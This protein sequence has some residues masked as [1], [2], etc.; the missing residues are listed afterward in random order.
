V[1]P[2]DE[3]LGRLLKLIRTRTGLTQA[4]LAAN[5]RVP[6]QDLKRLESGAAGNVRLDRIRSLYEAVDGRA[7]TT[8]WWNGASADRLL[9]E[10]HAA[11]VEIVVRLF[12][13]R[14][15][16]VFVELSFS[17]FGERGSID[18]FCALPSRAAIAGCEVKSVIGSLEET[19]RT[20]DVKVRLA[21]NIAFK[22]L[23][24][25]P[26]AVGRLLI[27]PRDMTI[28]RSIDSHA[29]T[30]DAIYPGRSREARAWLRDPAESLSAIWFVSNGPN[31]TTVSP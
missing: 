12:R 7:R 2:E 10:R 17:E 6:L 24:W 13:E 26:R 28:R 21:P 9:D 22:R 25:R 3:R 20:F 4:Q 18:V 5:A 16:Q 19:D 11:I 30:M 23:G 15:W 31:T 1:N 29:S 14:G 27:L 8:G